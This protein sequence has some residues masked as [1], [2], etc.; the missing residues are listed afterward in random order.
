MKIKE[1]ALIYLGASDYECPFCHSHI[2]D[3]ILYMIDKPFKY[4]PC[5]GEKVSFE[6]IDDSFIHSYSKQEELCRVKRN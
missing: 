6:R 5:C 1:T 4:C 3:E 2:K